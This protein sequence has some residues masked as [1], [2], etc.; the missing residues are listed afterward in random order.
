MTISFAFLL[1]FYVL[2]LSQKKS[3]LFTTGCYIWGTD[4][5]TCTTDSLNDQWRN[6]N[7]QYCG[8]RVNYPICI[9]KVQTLPASREFPEGRWTQYSAKNK[10]DWV[11]EQCE[12]HIKERRAL[13]NNGTLHRQNA[14]EWGEKGRIKRRFFH[15]P[16]CANAYRNLFCYIN[17]PRC[18]PERDLTLPTCRSACENFFKSCLYGRDLWRCGQ[19][20]FFNGY[21]PEI[22]TAAI[23]GNV[24]YMRDYFPGQP[25]RENKFNRAGKEIP[26]CTPSVVGQGSPKRITDWTM[27]SLVF[28]VV[29]LF[30]SVS[31][32]F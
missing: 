27:V 24:S 17:F 4:S 25:W 15:R 32:L 30:T 28:C 19:S 14:D 3:Y 22:P 20:K 8:F 5:G 31:T 7:L 2:Q 12:G 23:G 6:E 1:S 21:V 29:C 9:P 18:D 13:E 16:D 26:V 11:A 10:D